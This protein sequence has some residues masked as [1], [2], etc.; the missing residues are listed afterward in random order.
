MRQACCTD[1]LVSHAE[2]GAPL[3]SAHL[4][5][6]SSALCVVRPWSI[7]ARQPDCATINTWLA[8]QLTQ[9]MSPSGPSRVVD[10]RSAGLVTLI[11]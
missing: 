6:I 4:Q 5:C 10:R 1:L 9:D 3:L 8:P 2:Q 7:A 11:C